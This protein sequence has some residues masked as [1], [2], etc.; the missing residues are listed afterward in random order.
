MYPDSSYEREPAIN[1]WLIR[2]PILF[3]SGVILTLAALAALVLAFQYAY[4][5][6]IV[7]GVSM[8]NTNLNGMTRAEAIAAVSNRFTYDEQAVFTFRYGD[9][10]WQMSAGEL[11]VSFDAEATVDEAL[12]AGHRYNLASDLAAQATIWLNGRSVA[13]IVRYDQQAAVDKLAQ[14]AQDIN[15]PAISATLILDGTNIATTPSQ[16]GLTVDVGATLSRLEAAILQLNTGGEIPLVVTEAL[17][18]VKDAES[19]A[20]RLRVALS[21]PVMLVAD[22]LKGGTLGPWAVSVDQIKQ[23][24]SIQLV[25]NGDGSK[26]YD[27]DVNLDV[28]RSSLEALAPGLLAP[29]QDARYRFNPETGQLEL[30]KAGVS[31][32]KLN[33]EATLERL[34]EGIFNATNR[35]VLMGFD[36]ELPTY[37]DSLSAGELGIQ[38]LVGEATTYYTGS[39]RS[40]IENIIQA[41]A[42]FDGIVIAPGEEFSFNTWLGDI[43]PETGFVQ[44]KIIF[45]GRTVEGVGG[46]VCQVSTTAYRAALKGG[47]PIVE[48]HSHGYRVGFYELGN[49]P[50]G[51]DAAI[52]QP[53]ADFRFQNDTPYHLLIET[54]VIPTNEAVQFRLYSTNPGRQVVLEG[55]VIQNVTPTKPTEYVANAEVPLGQF[56]QIDWAK[57]G[58]DVTFTRILLDGSG[59]EIRRDTIYTHY[60]PWAAV[61]E[62]APSDPRTSTG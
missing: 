1:P 58:A 56:R 55:P 15:R 24:L 62:V 59:Q 21:G 34:K 8:M 51:L 49:T 50:P 52:F 44:G 30:L 7:P 57:E 31:G 47:F 27:V 19:A 11:G 45:G 37:H 12:A 42:R 17:P 46:G 22:D 61:V 43:S 20:A 28:F 2:L 53:D 35:I 48:R 5:G 39:T 6:R 41:A 36:Y 38:E 40:R 29:P 23:L 10:F 33:V 54:T 60:L 13:P 18:I 25:D 9:Q 3:V 26:S 32:R 14:I 16:P 4:A